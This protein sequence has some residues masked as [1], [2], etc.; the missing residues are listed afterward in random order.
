MECACNI[1]KVVK[2]I[3]DFTFYKLCRISDVWYFVEIFVFSSSVSADLV[4]E[5][6]G[7]RGYLLGGSSRSP[8]R[9]LKLFLEFSKIVDDDFR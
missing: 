1:P 3:V 7:I 4:F 9:R 5:I 6:I 8:S 2:P